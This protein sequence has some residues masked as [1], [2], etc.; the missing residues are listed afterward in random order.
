MLLVFE[1]LGSLYL[2]IG[3]ALL[4][5]FVV[6]ILHLLRP[7]GHVDHHPFQSLQLHSTDAQHRLPVVSFL[8]GLTHSSSPQHLVAY[9][10]DILLC[11]FATLKCFGRAL[12]C[13]LFEDLDEGGELRSRGV[14]AALV[15]FGEFGPCAFLGQFID[16]SFLIF[17]A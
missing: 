6:L 4:V 10:P 5:D 9:V 3:L 15:L 13:F 17:E 8:A 16:G 12:I 11:F 2:L 1:Y 7:V 14:V